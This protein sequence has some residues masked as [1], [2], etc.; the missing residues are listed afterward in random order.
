[1]NAWMKREQDRDLII[2]VLDDLHGQGGIKCRIGIPL[3]ADVQ[4]IIE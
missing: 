2:A 4:D 1:M 3:P